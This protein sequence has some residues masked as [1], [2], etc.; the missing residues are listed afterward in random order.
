[1][2]LC[3]LADTLRIFKK[4]TFIKGGAVYLK[5]LYK[6]LCSFCAVAI[7]MSCAS[8]GILA[9]VNADEPVGKMSAIYGYVLNDYIETFGVLSTDKDGFISN[10]KKEYPSPCGVVY[11]DILNFDNNSNPYLV[12]FVANS[13]YKTA[14]CHI[15][16]YND[17]L[18][19]AQRLAIIEKPYDKVAKN[20]AGE[21]NIGW[22][23]DKRFITYAT[24][25]DGILKAKEVYTAIS[26]EIFMYINNPSDISESGVMDFNESYFHSGID[27]SDYNKSLDVFFSKLKDSAAQSVNYENI[28][29]ALGTEDKMSLNRTLIKAAAYQDFDISRYSDM[30]EYQEALNITTSAAKFTQL[31][32]FYSLSDELYY[33]KFDTNISNYNYAL[34]RRCDLADNG[35]QILKVR[36]DC[37]PLSDIELKELRLSYMNNPLLLEKASTKLK[38]KE[39]SD[40]TPEPSDITVKVADDEPVTITVTPAPT[41]APADKPIKLVKIFGD[42][43]KLPIA[44][45]AGIIS[46]GLIVFLWV[47][48]LYD[49]DK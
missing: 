38:L 49:S 18:E 35:Y 21:F 28:A 4:S 36:T 48:M 15:W 14:S 32:A 33:A 40:T 42:G 47:Y 3:K 34:L 31:S 46:A 6:L 43:V 17:E 44:C 1:M 13:E 25:E 23:D 5:I 29:Y 24:Y 12:I 11:G 16:L 8:L 39:L 19:K 9:P 7:F 10:S 27:I 26:G 45:A 41:K 37:I 2:V 20:R 30:E 22:N